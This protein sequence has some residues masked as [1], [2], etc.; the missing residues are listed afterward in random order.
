MLAAIKIEIAG[1]RDFR[2][3]YNRYQILLKALVNKMSGFKKA[4]D[5]LFSKQSIKYVCSTHFWGPVSNFGLPVAAILDLKKDAELIS[6]PMTGSLIIYS[7][8]FMR[9]SL[10]VSP[11]NYLLF[12]CHLINDI[13]QIGQGI[14]WT[15]F[16]M[17]QDKKPIAN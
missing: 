2:N 17:A 10:A 9:Y 11:K 15:Q 8:V 3:S 14:R 6:G 4:T 16:H 13:A 5:F 1:D 12:G 7:M